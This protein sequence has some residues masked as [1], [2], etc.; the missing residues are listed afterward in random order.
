MVAQ[1]GAD[2]KLNARVS[3][4]DQT[5]DGITVASTAGTF[6]ADACIVATG[7]N[8]WKGIEFAPGLSPEKTAFTTEELS[9]KGGKVYVE[10]KGRFED[11]RWSAIGS[12]IVSV[13]PHRI[14]DESSVVV[15]FTS[16]EHPFTAVTKE[17]LQQEINGFDPEAE[18]LSFDHHDWVADDLVR[19]TWGNFRPGQFTKY[20]AQAL[21]PEGRVHFATA[22][23]AQGWRGFFDG[24]LE[25]GI[26]AGRTV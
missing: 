8:V 9:G 18:V 14:G 3:R 19:G 25:S 20:F 22:D 13:L 10:L 15:V 16:A 2:I 7:L 5:A 11:S 17:T 24:A 1:A 12:P 26:R 6:A 4:V 21:K 23:I